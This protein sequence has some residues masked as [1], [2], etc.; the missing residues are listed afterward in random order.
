M[1][2]ALV[3]AAVL[4]F[5]ASMSQAAILRAWLTVDNANPNVGQNFT[6]SIWLQVVPDPALTAQLGHVEDVSQSGIESAA[7]SIYQQNPHGNYSAQDAPGTRQVATV[8]NTGVGGFD[9]ANTPANMIDTNNPFFPD[10][11]FDA[12]NAAGS[13]SGLDLTIGVGGPVL[14]CTERWVCLKNATAYLHVTMPYQIYQGPNMAP[15][16]S[17]GQ[18]AP[19][20]RYWDI[21]DQT[22]SGL[23]RTNFTNYSIGILDNG[24][25]TPGADLVLNPEPATLV[26]L[27]LGAVGLVRRNRRA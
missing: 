1:K 4:C 25:F 24:V 20:A 14:L 22:G 6:V 23:Y 19:A 9:I 27:A 15:G 21:N 11:D 13:T 5:V 3:L 26:L 10:G 17:I 18:L 8:F 2:K 7:V 12:I 16:L